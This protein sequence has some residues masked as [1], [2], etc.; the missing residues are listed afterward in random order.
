MM[1]LPSVVNL[2]C[3]YIVTR[4]SDLTG[5]TRRLACNSPLTEMFQRKSDEAILELRRDFPWVFDHV[6]AR[7]CEAGGGCLGYAHVRAQ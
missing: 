2:F 4:F 1:I 5:L 3:H 7:G 6:V